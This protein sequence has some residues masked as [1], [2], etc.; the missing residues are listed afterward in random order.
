MEPRTAVKVRYGVD[1]G[2]HF[3][4]VLYIAVEDTQSPTGMTWRPHLGVMTGLTTNEGAA[5]EHGKALAKMIGAEFMEGCSSL[6]REP[7]Q[8]NYNA[9][10]AVGALRKLIA[11][12]TTIEPPMVDLHGR[13]LEP[14]TGP[15]RSAEI[16]L[17]G[18]RAIPLPE[19]FVVRMY[20][21]HDGWFDVSG[22][23][24]KEEATRIW[25]EK[26]EQGTTHIDYEDKAGFYYKIFFA[27]T[28][29]TLTRRIK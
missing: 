5:T 29:M 21:R 1:R 14:A 19:L 8:P 25:N 6:D 18:P 28:T 15:R 24:T 23:V 27:D 10:F 17:L 3:C 16:P 4:A 12:P 9:P 13:P 26:T 20:D 11:V 2:G 7:V 22:N